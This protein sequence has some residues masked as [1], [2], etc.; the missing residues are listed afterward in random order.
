MTVTLCTE[1]LAVGAVAVGSWAALTA[2]EPDPAPPQDAYAV[3]VDRPATTTVRTI[4]ARR[5]F[6]DCRPT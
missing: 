5:R 4:A 3:P 6:I 2:P 1:A